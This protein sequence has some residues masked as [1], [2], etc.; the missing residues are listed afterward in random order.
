MSEDFRD[1]KVFGPPFWKTYDI[2][3]A[4][5]P[6][7]PNKKERE[8]AKMFFQSQKYLIPCAICAH[9]YRKIYKNY[10]PHLESRTALM[11]W[12]ATLKA[13][14]AAHVEK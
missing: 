4:T 6:K 1:P 13:K 14:V 9:N 7:H 12:V 11:A 10:P 3:A 8:A 5:Y 2:I